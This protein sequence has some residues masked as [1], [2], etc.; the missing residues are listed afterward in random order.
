MT[1]SVSEN[2]IVIRVRDLVVKFGAQTVLNGLSLDLRRGEILG[3][4]GASG[5]GKSVL[6]RTIIGLLPRHSGLIEV[7]GSEAKDAEARRREIG[8]RWGFLL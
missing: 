6:L 4:V 8:W 3:V 2:E 5:G 1:V 7:L